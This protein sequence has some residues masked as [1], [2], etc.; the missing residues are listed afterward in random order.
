MLDTDPLPWYLG[1]LAIV[2]ASSLFVLWIRQ[3]R[4]TLPLP[5][6][7]TPL[8]ILGNTLDIPKS[9][10]ARTFKEWSQKYGDIIYLHSPSQPMLV[11][12]TLESAVEL[13]DRRSSKYSSRPISVM[14]E[15]MTWSNAFGLREYSQE[16]REQRKYFHE[17]FH[18]GSVEKY[19]P[20]QTQGIRSFLRRA[21]APG[22]SYK[23]QEQVLFTLIS[24]VADVV[25]GIQVRDM[26]AD[27]VVNARTALEGFVRS[28]EPGA[29]WVEFFPFLRFIPS[30]VPGATF[31]RFVEHYRPFVQRTFRGPFQI[32]KDSLV[33]VRHPYQTGLLMHHKQE[34]ENSPPCA[35]KEL[36]YRINNKDAGPESYTQQEQMVME[37]MG[38]VIAAATDTTHSV[39]LCF[40]LAM[41][42]YP[43][44]Q[45]KAQAELDLH[46]GP[47]RLPS[48]KDR[49]SLTYIRAIVL[50]SLR[51][52]P[53][54]PL[55]IPHLVLAD[56]EYNGYRI[57]KGTTILANV[58]A[59]LRD[60]EVYPSPEIFNPDRFLKDG[61]LNP[62]IRD[63]RSVAFGFGR[64]I[65]P[66]RH[67]SQN[68]LFLFIA[69][70]LHVFNVVP[71]TDSAGNPVPIEVNMTSELIR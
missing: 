59:M 69:S 54:A 16:W 9:H 34:L 35:T 17:C 5:P 64:R 63:P 2:A 25:Y 36:L 71:A 51:W 66:G 14:A 68:T 4:A 49:T 58:W 24:I 42:K 20:L 3:A 70:V 28:G 32:V 48:I 40:L 7:P 22:P 43:E 62:A 19:V 60:P 41:A 61:A 55:C 57:P 6:G 67:Y 1:L 30:W 37:S 15:L 27:Y 21:L 46:V 26:N 56:D 13:L 10:P 52:Q 12:N 29:F 38:T 53:T 23:I 47:H 44:V 50:E 18:Q 11:L 39:L 31:K 65:C 45:K 8:P 33:S